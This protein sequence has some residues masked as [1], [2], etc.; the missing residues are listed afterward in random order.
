LAVSTG[1]STMSGN[2]DLE[3]YVISTSSGA[4]TSAIQSATGTDAVGA[5]AVAALP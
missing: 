5:V 3:A 2:P 4:L 1:G